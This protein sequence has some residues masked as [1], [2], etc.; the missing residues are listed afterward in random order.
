MTAPFRCDVNQ[1]T[2]DISYKDDDIDPGLSYDYVV[3]RQDA[4]GEF[5]FQYGPQTVVAE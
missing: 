2:P 3:I 4:G 1:P 5:L